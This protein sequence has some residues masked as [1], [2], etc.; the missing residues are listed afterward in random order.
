M[1]FI[2]II[3]NILKTEYFLYLWKKVPLEYS[4]VV[5]ASAQLFIRK[6]HLGE[7]VS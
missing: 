5:K 7:D 6:G 2:E 3:E 1:V 4:H